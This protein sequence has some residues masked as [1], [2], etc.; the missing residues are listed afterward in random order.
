[1]G[2]NRKTLPSCKLN[3][4]CAVTIKNAIQKLSTTQTR[5]HREYDPEHYDK[6][7]TVPPFRPALHFT[8]AVSTTKVDY[9]EGISS[10]YRKGTR[11]RKQNVCPSL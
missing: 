5:T 10:K 1:M 7:N 11:R 8:S 3:N 2:A 9:Q 4:N 6:R